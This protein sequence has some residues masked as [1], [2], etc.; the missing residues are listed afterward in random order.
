MVPLPFLGVF[1][2][3][4]QES[5][6]FLSYLVAKRNADTLLLLSFDV[7][8]SSRFLWSEYRKF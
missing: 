4:N 5:D 7:I 8:P 6:G 3:G 2:G 1:A